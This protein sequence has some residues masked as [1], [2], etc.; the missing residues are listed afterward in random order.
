MREDGDLVRRALKGE[1]DAWEQIV[2]RHQET[3]AAKARK[4]RLSSEEA[5]DAIQETWV[6][7]F[8]G[9]SGLREPDSL[10]SWLRAIMHHECVKVFHARQR[11]TLTPDAGADVADPQP[12]VERLVMAGEGAAMVRAAI[13]RLPRRQRE[14]V[15]CLATEDSYKE[16]SSAMSLPLGSIGPMRA[17][18]FA[19]LRTILGEQCGADFLDAA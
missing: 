17:R 7:A 10:S 14:L 9:L 5:A 15:S 16:I 1:D 4:F 8:L 2:L 3:L 18:A 11:E 12:A 19:R 6:R 13:T